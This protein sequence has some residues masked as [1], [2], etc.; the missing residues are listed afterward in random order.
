[1]V[2]MPRFEQRGGRTVAISIFVEVVVPNAQVRAFA[3]ETPRGQIALPRR[4][5]V[6]RGDYETR[7]TRT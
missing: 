5:N 6:R 1:M 7:H 3:A 2:E 4:C